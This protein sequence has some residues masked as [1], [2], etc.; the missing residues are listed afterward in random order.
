M[1]NKV[2]LT[3]KWAM[4]QK[5]IR[6]YEA[7]PYRFK[8]TVDKIRAFDRAVQVVDYYLLKFTGNIK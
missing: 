5:V 2:D 3:G 7:E 8:H 4:G 6:G 1:V